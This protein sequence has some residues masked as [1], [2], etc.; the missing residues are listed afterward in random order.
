MDISSI[1]FFFLSSQEKMKVS[2][3]SFLTDSMTSNRAM[4]EGK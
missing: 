1:T 3:T 2:F 4:E